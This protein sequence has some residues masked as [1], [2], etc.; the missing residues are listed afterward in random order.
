MTQSFD[1][2]NVKSSAFK[3]QNKGLQEWEKVHWNI[4]LFD[5]H[6][7][8]FSGLKEKKKQIPKFFQV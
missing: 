1:T 2:F 7:K 4:Y 8:G 5:V 6:Q 3:F